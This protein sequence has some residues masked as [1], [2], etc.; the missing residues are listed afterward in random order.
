MT[1]RTQSVS[2]MDGYIRVSRRMGR[3]GESYLSK[4]IQREAIDRWAEYKRVEIVEWF[5][6]EDQTG[7]KQ[8][9]PAL[10]RAVERAVSGETDGIVS[11]KIDRFSRTTSGGLRDLERL[12]EAGA[13]L[14][15]VV[16]DIDTASAYGK[17]VY[18]IILA[19]SE[20]FLENIKA[21]WVET[22]TRA[23]RRGAYIARTPYGYTRHEGRLIPHP[24]E[25]PIVTEAFKLAAT[26]GLSATLAYLQRAA[27]ARE[28]KGQVVDI[29]WTTST[30]RRVLENRAYLG[31]SRN[32]NLIKTDTHEALT[33]RPIFEAAQSVPARR[34]ASDTFPLSGVIR[35]G[36]CGA[37]MIG[38]RGGQGQRTY[39]CSATLALSKQKC[40]AG[41]VVTADRIETYLNQHARELLAGLRA[42]VSGPDADDLE[43]LEEALARAEAELDEFASDLTMRRALGERYHRH[44]EQRVRAVEAAQEAYREAAKRA[45]PQLVLTGPEMVDDPELLAPVLRSLYGQ[46]LIDRGR[47]LKIEQRVRFVPVDGDDA[48]G[49]ASA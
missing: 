46:I 26:S 5:E 32:G 23:H 34:R 3:D 28:R 16:E 36:S 12:K 44:L 35:C 38:S 30:V 29:V 22:K 39:R 48:A 41:A 19:V 31:E 6:D 33:T 42:T 2:R 21:G 20:A 9:R 11:W 27:P 25:G 15:F 4:K 37:E 7:G 18:T 49:V 1:K 10:K 47:G 43:S 8:D 24:D 14:A 45:Q 17:M 13:R 40:D